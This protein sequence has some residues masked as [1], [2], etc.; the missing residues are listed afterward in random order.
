MTSDLGKLE[1]TESIE[2]NEKAEKPEDQLKQ[3][4]HDVLEC[5]KDQKLETPEK[6]KEFDVLAG[7]IERLQGLTGK[8]SFSEVSDVL[9]DCGDSLQGF[10]GQNEKLDKAID[11]IAEK[12]KDISGRYEKDEGLSNFID[13]LCTLLKGLLPILMGI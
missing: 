9:N 1:H 11:D 13:L 10:K 4:S 2:K 5:I 6:S 3:V 8:E 7:N 12:I